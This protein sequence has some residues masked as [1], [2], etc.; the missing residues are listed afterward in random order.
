MFSDPLYQNTVNQQKGL[1]AV[2]SAF[3]SGSVLTLIVVYAVIVLIQFFSCISALNDLN[4]ASKYSFSN[5]VVA[6]TII[7]VLILLAAVA[8]P[9]VG[10]IVAYAKSKNP[11]EAS[12]PKA[13]LTMLFVSSVIF[14]VFYII[15]AFLVFM[16]M[17][18]G[19]SIMDSFLDYFGSE[20]GAY[21]RAASS[22]LVGFLFI[23]LIVVTPFILMFVSLTMFCSSAK[24][25]LK[26]NMPTLKGAKFL[27]VMSIIL[28]I[29]AGLTTLLNLGTIGSN[30][31]NWLLMA[32]Q[33]AV[34]IIIP[35]CVTGYIKSVYVAFGGSGHTTTVNDTNTYYNSNQ[36]TYNPPYNTQTGTNNYYNP[37]NSTYNSQAGSNNYYNPQ[38]Q[39]S[40]YYNQ[41]QNQSYNQ[42]YNNTANGYYNGQQNPNYNNQSNV[43]V[44]SQTNNASTYNEVQNAPQ[45]G[46]D[47]LQQ[48]K[49]ST[50]SCPGCG[51]P[52]GEGASFC[53][54]CGYKL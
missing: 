21:G 12:N 31:F 6:I 8:L 42:P 45:N 25:M 19:A 9:L 36:P 41:P 24:K 11:S 22:F 43:P 16:L 26:Y 33:T 20:F 3:S 37:Q 29:L 30:F 49:A 53:P 27:R 34:Y 2:K 23:C 1:S 17:L 44:Y 28:A 13:G 14:L 51:T 54:N 5:G 40:A 52:V 46:F 35:V 32:A 7:L 38:Q 47:N 15:F 18:F 39:N 48:E 50:A 4:T 10:L